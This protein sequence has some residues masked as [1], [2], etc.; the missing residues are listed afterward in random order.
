MNPRMLSPICLVLASVACGGGN[1]GS[2]PPPVPPPACSTGIATPRSFPNLTFESPVVMRQAP[3][4][5]SRWFVAEQAGLIR[6]FDN[7]AAVPGTL[8]FLDIR[9]RVNFSGEAGLLG[10]A[11]HPDFAV[12]GR[13]FVNY[14]NFAGGTL[15]SI[16]SEF[17]SL[18]GGLTLDPNSE[19][20]LLTV[21]KP[22]ANHNGGN[23]TFG[24][25]GFLYIGLGDGGGS[26]DPQENAQNP[27]R[28]LG[29][30]LRIDVDTQPGGAPYAI[31]AGP[32]G[33]PFAG[34]PLCNVD[35]TG[36]QGC[37]EIYALGF[38][39]PWRWSFD[40]QTGELWVG[41]VGQDS[42]EEID[43]VERG[44]NYGWDT[45]EGAHCFEPMT[46]C[47]TSGLTD[48]VAEYGRDLGF[49]ITGGYVYRGTQS[50]IVAGR[51]FFADFG[52][53][54]ASLLP[55]GVDRFMVEPL[56]QPDCA[57][58]EASGPLQVSSF[59]EDLDGELYVLDYGRGHIRQLVFTD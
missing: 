8:D 24:P 11:F 50:T 16:T 58:P 2:P 35:G 39:N 31:P 37:P 10:L 27:R 44:G 23:I 45:R 22:A 53:M 38:R 30:L 15:R 1:D 52:G 3:F 46:D 32:T 21:E 59:A 34:N 26:G 20:V 56:V 48:P 25:D 36:T 41:D 49:S 28:L 14:S 54:I 57:P 33:N 17:T 7:N 12:N 19:R 40:R 29:K 47:S 4:D 42:F 13:A 5:A 43:R 9:G 51:Y 18:N 6:S 55:D